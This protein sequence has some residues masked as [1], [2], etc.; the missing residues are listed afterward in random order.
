MSYVFQ[1]A[2]DKVVYLVTKDQVTKGQV[3]HNIVS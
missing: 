2:F 1:F 3:N